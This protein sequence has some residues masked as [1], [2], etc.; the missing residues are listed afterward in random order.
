MFIGIV[1]CGCS[2]VLK[3]AHPLV[4]TT[5]Q[6]PH[7]KV[8]FIRPRPERTMAMADNTLTIDL[9]QQPLQN[10]AK[11]E[12]SLA[13]LQPGQVWITL[14]SKS[15]FGPEHRIKKMSKSRSFTFAAGQ[16]YYIAIQAVDGEF[17]GA[18]FIAQDVERA[19][20]ASLVKRA[21]ATGL[22]KRHK[23]E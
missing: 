12:Y 18:H 23:I 1:M 16:T 21:K 13:R 5:E 15:T 6:A 11:G 10:L 9:D 20:A 4:V 14:T 17:R 2:S 7:A 22:A 8:Y 3:S 19:T